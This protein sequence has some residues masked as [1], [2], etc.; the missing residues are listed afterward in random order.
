MSTDVDKTLNTLRLLIP[1]KEENVAQISEQKADTITVSVAEQLKQ[2]K[3]LLD[4]GLIEQ[5]DYDA[6]KAQLLNLK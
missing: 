3:E 1:Q 4:N 2:Y 6:L 5:S